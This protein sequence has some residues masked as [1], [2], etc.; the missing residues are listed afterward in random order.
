[1]C[2]I[3]C[4]YTTNRGRCLLDPNTSEEELAEGGLIY[5]LAD[6]AVLQLTHSGNDR[7]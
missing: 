6:G 2:V 1:M 7:E 3:L 5:C 4:P